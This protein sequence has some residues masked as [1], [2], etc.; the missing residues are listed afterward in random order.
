MG[1]DPLDE[2]LGAMG[3]V[4]FEEQQRHRQW[5]NYG[6]VDAKD[7]LADLLEQT[8]ALVPSAVPTG[9]GDDDVYA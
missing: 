8:G 7:Q 4:E 1:P 2:F 9:S 6:R 3:G 5:W